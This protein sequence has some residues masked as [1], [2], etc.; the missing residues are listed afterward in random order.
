MSRHGNASDARREA[1]ALA[2]GKSHQ[3]VK[4]LQEHFDFVDN[5]FVEKTIFK[6]MKNEDREAQYEATAAAIAIKAAAMAARRGGGAG[7]SYDQYDDYDEFEDYADYDTGNRLMMIAG[8]GIAVLA[9]VFGVS[10][11]VWSGGSSGGR[12]NHASGSRSNYFV[13]DLPAVITNIYAGG[14]TYQVRMNIQL[15]LDEYGDAGKVESALSAIMQSVIERIQL[16]DAKDLQ[17]REKIQA[18]RETLTR[19]IQKAMGRTNLNGIL[20]Q[21]IQVI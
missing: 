17:K 6:Q 11:F 7:G 18:L 8:A 20:F 5:R 4:V 1:R 2:S 19:E 14:K 21:N 16:T 3:G 13:Y 10:M 15:E 9:L 12:S